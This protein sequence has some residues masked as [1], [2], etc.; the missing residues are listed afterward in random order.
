MQAAES[1]LGWSLQEPE[2]G[3]V[4]FGLHDP[5][6]ADYAL[7][8]R[9]SYSANDDQSLQQAVL[10]EQQAART[11]S[12]L[13]E[14]DA[15]L[16]QIARRAVNAQVSFGAGTEDDAGAAKVL[17]RLGNALTRL[18]WVETQVDGA[19]VG[20]SAIGWTNK[21]ETFWH[22]S[23]GAG[24]L[25]LHSRSLSAAVTS[26]LALL[27]LAVIT[28]RAAVKIAAMTALPGGAVAALPLAWKTIR[29]VIAE[30]ELIKGLS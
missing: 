7:L 26:R 12:S 8:W 9:R 19:L 18:A 3:E 24:S 13:D 23:A 21:T 10:A 5:G 30:I 22:S 16:D 4:S 25:E 2:T 11:L 27:R 28:A 15:N 14:L 20:R 29:M 17:E 6:E 1:L